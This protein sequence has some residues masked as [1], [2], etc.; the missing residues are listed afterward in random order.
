VTSEA[1]R[2]QVEP[3]QSQRLSILGGKFDEALG[4]EKDL[5]ALVSSATDEPSHAACA[6]T[7]MNLYL[8]LGDSTRATRAASEFLTKRDAWA[9]DGQFDYSVLSYRTRYLAGTMG[10]QEFRAKR[11]AWSAKGTAAGLRGPSDA[12]WV[13]GFAQ[14]VKTAADADDALRASPVPGALPT[15]SP[16]AGSTTEGALGYVSLLAGKLDEAKAHLGRAAHACLAED[17]LAKTQAELHLGEALEKLGDTA[18][19]CASYRVV[20]SRWGREPRSV[21][22]ARA[23]ARANQLHCP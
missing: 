22:A 7:E 18:G 10:A 3:D 21:S 2:K 8:E 11:D 14:A 19:A 15:V 20:L 13:M 12:T 6:D 1:A 17:A 5:V 16:L 23:R 4:L 9:S